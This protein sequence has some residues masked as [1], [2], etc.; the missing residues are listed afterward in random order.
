[1]GAFEYKAMDARGREVKGV[2]EGDTPRQ[3]RQQLREKG[4]MPLSVEEVQQ[5]EAR[6]KRG[7]S[8][9]RG[10]SATDLA[11]IT[12]QLSTLVRSGMPVDESLMAVSQQTDKA[13]LKSMVVAVRSKVLEGHSL[14]AALGGF[15]Q[16]FNNLYQ[17]TVS[18]GEQS[19]HLNAV[20][21]RLADYTEARQQLG[22]KMAIALL[23]PVLLT[24]VSIAVVVMLLAYVVPKVVEVFD[25][26]GRELPWLT[27][28]LISI[29]DFI[30]DYG[31]PLFGVVVLA[32]AL[33]VYLLR[34]P[35]LKFSFHRSLLG[36]PLVGRLVRGINTARFARTFAILSSA[37]VPVLEGL[38]ISAQVMSNLPMQDAVE[39]AAK[40]V[41]E[42]GNLHTSL[43]ASGYFPPM[44][45]HLI[46]S[47]EASGKLE[48]ML[49]RAAD[50]QER[51]LDTLR[52][53]LLGIFEPLLIL[54]MG[55][56]VLI[57]V[58]AILLPIFDMNQM[59]K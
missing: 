40:R 19:G 48:E 37:G 16:V 57:I 59:V 2:L 52:S 17:S 30:R 3:I 54:F 53:A 8:L 4:W 6:E 10:V 27:R 44:T 35:A 20:L 1:M 55:G 23:Y 34:I 9:R 46:A 12:R 45:L 50:N 47:G 25:N 43:A 42:G 26:I 58:L 7:F 39:S 51:E 49:E 56:V 11:L 5:R 33:A 21:D 28:T 24:L 18:A 29:S 41:R 15:P 13:R 31:I 38:R 14:A 32:A 22:Q 36:V